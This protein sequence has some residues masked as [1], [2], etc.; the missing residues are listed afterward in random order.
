MTDGMPARS[1]V[2]AVMGSKNLKAV[3]VKGSKSLTLHDRKAFRKILPAIWE[4]TRTAKTTGTTFP[5]YGTPAGV[6][7]FNT[8][9]MLPTH[10]FQAGVFDGADKISGQV[11]KDTIVLRDYGCFSCP[12][13][14]G[15]VTEVKKDGARSG[16]AWARSMRPS[17]FW[18]RRAG[19]M[20]SL[21]LP[22]PAISAMNPA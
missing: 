12:I 17:P 7:F 18:D 11:M 14:C 21:L 4:T 9:G 5:T 20:I 1:G 19:S 13:R 2:G 16:R 8:L 15:K 3:V 10:N 22:G 6:A